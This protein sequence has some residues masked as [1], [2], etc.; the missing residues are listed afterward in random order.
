MN[1]NCMDEMPEAR[2]LWVLLVVWIFVVTASLGCSITIGARQPCSSEEET[3]LQQAYEQFL[4]TWAQAARMRDEVGLETVATGEMLSKM[5]RKIQLA[6][7]GYRLDWEEYS[8]VRFEV[9]SYSSDKAQAVF[10][11][12]RKTYNTDPKTGDE[13]LVGSMSELHEI[14]FVKED[15]VWKV[16][17]RSVSIID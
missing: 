15:G 13:Y 8:H 3:E 2:K 14:T 1:N 6:R 4:V 5:Q 9:V 17:Q 12:L 10:R 11:A 16:S 7:Q